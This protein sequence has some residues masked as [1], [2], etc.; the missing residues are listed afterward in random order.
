MP[1][2]ISAVFGPA[3]V[4]RCKKCRGPTDTT[5]NYIEYDK[6]GWKYAQEYAKFDDL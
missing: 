2:S 6:N 4:S 3:C 5:K 1:H